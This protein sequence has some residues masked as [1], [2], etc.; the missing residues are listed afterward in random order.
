M[1]FEIHK[2]DLVPDPKSK[3]VPTG[4][5]PGRP[6]GSV[7][8]KMNE[9]EKEEFMKESLKQILDNHLSYTEYWRLCKEK[10]LSKSQANH[11]WL[12]IWSIVKRKFELE[13]DKL[14]SKHLQKYW[15][16]HDKAK[17]SGDLN[18][19]RQT[20]NDIAKMMGMNE[21]DK[22]HVTGT[23]IKLNFGEPIE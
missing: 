16:I 22:V 8:H 9:A 10:G 6:K 23:S 3:W 1:D 12:R 17:E 21:P 14:V 13:K 15:D 20:L 5:P 2:E 7:K 11:Y 19:A 4:N 18:T